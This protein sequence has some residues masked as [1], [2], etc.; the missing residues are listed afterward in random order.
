ME[1]ISVNTWER[2]QLLQIVSGGH[3]PFGEVELGLRALS[4][5]R[6]SDEEKKAIHWVDLGMGQFHWNGSRE[7]GLEFDDDV[8]RLV[9][10]LVGG[11]TAWPYDERVKLLRE[12][13]L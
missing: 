8:W 4:I 7:Y 5:L 9:Q 13:V 11:Y 6:F 1:T 2:A 12:K 10:V 3:G